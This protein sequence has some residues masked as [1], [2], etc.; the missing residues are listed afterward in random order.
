MKAG[1]HDIMKLDRLEIEAEIECIQDNRD[2]HERLLKELKDVNDRM[3][4]HF[5]FL[6]KMLEDE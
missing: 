2:E 6:M 1:R 5:N 3:W 4:I